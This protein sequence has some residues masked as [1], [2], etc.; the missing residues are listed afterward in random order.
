MWKNIETFFISN[1]YYIDYCG[2]HIL[3]NCHNVISQPIS[4]HCAVC[5][6]YS[7]LSLIERNSDWRRIVLV[8]CVEELNMEHQEEF[9]NKLILNV[10]ILIPQE[11]GINK[12]YI[13]DTIFFE[14]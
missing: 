14:D 12:S 9:N 11:P 3:S 8:N 5:S 10:Q 6:L 4:Q 1:L 7:I 13:P 2:V